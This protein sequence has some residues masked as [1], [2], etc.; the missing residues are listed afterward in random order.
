MNPS[1]DGLGKGCME[2]LYMKCQ[3]LSKTKALIFSAQKQARKTKVVKC[4]IVRKIHTPLCR[5]REEKSEM[6]DHLESDSKMVAQKE[7]K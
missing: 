5:L 1:T 6:V 7:W 4:N 2:S 3:K